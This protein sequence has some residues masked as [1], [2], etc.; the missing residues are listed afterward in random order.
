MNCEAFE[1]LLDVEGVTAL[2]ATATA[3]AQDCPRCARALEAARSVD[4]VLVAT[5]S[6]RAPSGFTDRV[7]ARIR[8]EAKPRAAAV[9][10]RVASPFDPVPAWIRFMAEPTIAGAAVLAALI[11]WQA[12]RLLELGRAWASAL[13]VSAAQDA[14]AG[15]SQWATALQAA[16]NDPVRLALLVAAASLAP[17]AGLFLFRW[18]ERLTIGGARRR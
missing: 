6:V 9:M 11:G 18:T 8:T 14:V 1:R 2:S 7:L 4:A 15:P 13:A 17:L 10:P 5:T 12:P 16:F 3:H